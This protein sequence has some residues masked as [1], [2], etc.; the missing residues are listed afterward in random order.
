M[1]G[2]SPATCIRALWLSVVLV[3]SVRYYSKLG[4]PVSL[5]AWRGSG[6][7]HE[8]GSELCWLAHYENKETIR[9]GASCKG[10][11]GR[12]KAAEH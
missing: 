10:E 1:E 7:V 4:N 6:G 11:E 8:L 3:Y 9:G 12:W 5:K 2:I